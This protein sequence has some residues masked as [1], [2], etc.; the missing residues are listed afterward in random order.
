[1]V[2]YITFTIAFNHV[3]KG[4]NKPTEKPGKTEEILMKENKQSNAAVAVRVL[5]EGL[6]IGS[7]IFSV[8]WAACLG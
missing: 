5:F 1:M 7:L 8:V 6:Y 4:R 2:F 3:N